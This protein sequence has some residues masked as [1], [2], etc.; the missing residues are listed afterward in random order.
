VYPE[1]DKDNPS[2]GN[3]RCTIIIKLNHFK[4]NG[5]RNQKFRLASQV[6]LILFISHFNQK[7]LSLSTGR[8]LNAKG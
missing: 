5:W 4:I 1:P 3:T 7:S 6:D 2:H 8:D